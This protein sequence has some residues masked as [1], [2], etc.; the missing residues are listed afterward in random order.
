MPASFSSLIFSALLAIVLLVL[1][2][3]ALLR[4]CVPTREL[5]FISRLT[6]APGVTTALSVLI[7][8]WSKVFGLKL[9]PV[10]PW[11]MMAVAVLALLVDRRRGTWRLANRISRRRLR[12][13]P[14][15]EWL[16]GVA[17][18]VVLAALLIVR[19]N[20]TRGWLVPPGI[21][22][23]HH[24]VIVQLLLEHHGLFDSWA[25]YSDA[26]TFT[27]HFGFHAVTTLFAWMSGSDAVFATFVMARVMGVCAMGA[28][29]G[30][31]RLWTRSSWGGVFA[32]A[33][34]EL[35]SQHLYFFDPP[36]RWTPLAGLAVLPSAL[37]LLSLFLQAGERPK[38][39]RLGLLCIMTSAGLVLAQYKTAVIFAVLATVLFWSRCIAAML[40]AQPYRRSRIIDISCRAFAIVV[41][42]SLLVAPRLSAVMETK[43]GQQLNRILFEAPPPNSIGV[44][45][46]TK[47]ISEL[48][49]SGFA[50]PQQATASSLALLAGLAILL[51]R[52][53][54]L[55]FVVGWAAVS[56][57][58]NPTLA[59]IYRAGLIDEISWTYAVPTAIAALAGL[60]VGLACEA[61]KRP[62]NL[63]WNG[64]LFV[65]ALL[66]SGWGAIRLPLVPD[67]SRFV[68]AEDLPVMEWIKAHV[69]ENEKIAGRGFF[70]SWF[71]LEYDA[72]MW[73]P[74][75]TR[76]LTNH[77]LLAAAL[78]KG[79]IADREK[80]RSFTAELYA[81]D[82][83]TPE[84]A[85]WMQ[86]QGYRWLYSGANAP[87]VHNLAPSEP[88][89]RDRKKLLDQM[90][91]NPAL[92][93]VFT[94][95]AAR[96]YRVK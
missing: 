7:F 15:G 23:P 10:T 65:G 31:V 44:G 67:V 81:R 68:L 37:V 20:S 32:A 92:E 12:R 60:T 1:P 77:M 35:Y 25:P 79:P 42:A 55:W 9:G 4:I 24:T 51:R 56:A 50:N 14:I 74:Y 82:M 11:L 17:L 30:L 71:V 89:E 22:S 53:E 95:G 8:T 70:H 94:Q 29:F 47:N 48:F 34:W 91:H 36:G 2:G 58:M 46:P 96:L 6:L 90:A 5:G 26:E 64:A 59:G 41:V 57:V 33:F 40:Q 18:V 66:L 28:L 19:F 93:L 88:A 87:A 75:F 83:S 13:I 43:T 54:A 27:Y 85:A 84:S 61:V 78:E 52:R 21:D 76:H 86:E 45:A 49:L 16:A 3:F 62:R 39:W 63:A 69:P 80:S 73:V 38:N 72:I